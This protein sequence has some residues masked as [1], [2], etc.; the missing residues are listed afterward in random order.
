MADRERTRTRERGTREVNGYEK[1]LDTRK[2]FEERQLG[3]PV[4]IQESDREFQ[5]NRQGRLLY[6][7]D[8]IQHK[9]TPLQDWM[10]FMNDIRTHSGKH[11]HQ[12]GLVIY[13]IEGRGYSIVDGERK[14]WEAGD[15]LLLPIKPEGVV[16]Q[17]FNLEQGKRCIWIAFINMPVMDHVAMECTQIENMPGFTG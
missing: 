11:R 6:F 10:V 8:P 3:G 13:V 12:G 7:L 14:D 1:F 9:D 4:V 16:H 2:K 5:M 15:L 17:H